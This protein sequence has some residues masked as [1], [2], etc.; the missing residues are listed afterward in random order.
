MIKGL[1]HLTG[2]SFIENIPRV[3]PTDLAARLRRG[4]WPVP[5]LFK[6]L[7]ERGKVEAEEMLRVFNMG[8]GMV[9]VVAPERAS[10]FQSLLGEESWVIGELVT[11]ERKVLLS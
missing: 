10:E 11:G 6:L 8:V 1:A 7:Q 3:L 4:S 5:P 2:G 9:A